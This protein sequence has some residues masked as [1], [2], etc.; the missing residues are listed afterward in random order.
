MT[1]TNPYQPPLGGAEKDG[2]RRAA[3]KG[4]LWELLLMGSGA[5]IGTLIALPFLRTHFP[6]ALG[7]PLIGS[8]VGG[9]ATRLHG[10]LSGAGT[11]GVRLNF[12]LC[13]IFLICGPALTLTAGAIILQLAG[14]PVS[15]GSLTPFVGL[16]A[17]LGMVTS[18]GAL[19]I[20]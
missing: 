2:A 14:E 9:V 17:I 8:V 20:R 4:A 16:G 1:D 10:M 13:A 11:E 5:T 19:F 18:V 7:G 6:W 12:R 3:R 15:I